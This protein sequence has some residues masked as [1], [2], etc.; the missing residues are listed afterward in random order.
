LAQ[1]P[2]LVQLV[3][4]GKL[5]DQAVCL[6]LTPYVQ[7]TSCLCFLTRLTYQP[8]D[9]PNMPICNEV[10]HRQPVGQRLITLGTRLQ[11]T[12]KRE[13]LFSITGEARLSPLALSSIPVAARLSESGCAPC[14]PAAPSGPG[15]TQLPSMP[16]PLAACQINDG[17]M[18]LH[19]ERE[20]FVAAH[21]MQANRQHC[22]SPGWPSVRRGYACLH[23]E[24]TIRD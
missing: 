12:S 3:A 23:T 6:M 5:T 13:I 15:S 20:V 16:T 24:S 21:A 2:V 8:Q 10:V 17:C 1:L 18:L 22:T 11:Q 9:R 14:P 4:K 7:Q 19:Q